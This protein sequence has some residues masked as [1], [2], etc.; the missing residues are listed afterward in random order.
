MHIT[1]SHRPTTGREIETY[2]QSTTRLVTSIIVIDWGT[3]MIN[4]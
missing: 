3:I 4:V 1:R 2:D